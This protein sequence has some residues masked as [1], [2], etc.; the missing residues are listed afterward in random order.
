MKVWDGTTPERKSNTVYAPPGAADFDTIKKQLIS[1]Q[2][3]ALSRMR[4]NLVELTN[5][6]ILEF[7]SK[8]IDNGVAI[9]LKVLSN[10]QKVILSGINHN[11]EFINEEILRGQEYSVNGWMHLESIKGGRVFKSRIMFIPMVGYSAEIINIYYFPKE[12]DTGVVN[13]LGESIISIDNKICLHMD[14]EY[15]NDGKYLIIY[16]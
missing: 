8:I 7:P 12:N 5:N 16:K 13:L 14:K 15:A 9:G 11:G 1:T 3:F 2:L 4:C 10:K 6:Q